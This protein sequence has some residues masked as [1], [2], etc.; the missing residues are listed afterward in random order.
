MEDNKNTY[1]IK[2]ASLNTGLMLG[3][4]FI[5]LSIIINMTGMVTNKYLSWVNYIILVL[6]IVI[7]QNNFKRNGNGFMSFGQGLGIG[8]FVT[9][10]GTVISTAFGYIYVSFIDSSVME[11][12]REAQV[13]EL[14]K[15]GLSPEQFDA[16]LEI[17]EKFLQPAIMYPMAL[18]FM[19]FFGF[20]LSL[21]ITIFTKKND[22]SLEI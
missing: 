4:A 20:L 5:A 6:F 11:T 21:I 1:T 13:I 9:A 12:L 2:D 15:Q 8:M 17:S 18:F 22:P 16:A 14:E 7:G 10:I 19:L 3:L